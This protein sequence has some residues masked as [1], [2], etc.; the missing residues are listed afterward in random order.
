MYWLCYDDPRQQVII[1][2][3][4]APDRYEH[5]YGYETEQE[6]IEAGNAA[7]EDFYGW[8]PSEP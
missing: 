8:K 1:Y 3:A 2:A 7:I 5:E 4:V 6:A